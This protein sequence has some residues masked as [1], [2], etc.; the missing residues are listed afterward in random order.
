MKPNDENAKLLPAER[1]FRI[2]IISG[3]GRRQYNCPGVDSKSRTLMLKMAE[4]L[5]QDWEIDYE[6]LGNVY[7]RAR[8]QSCNA[9]VSTSMALCVYPCNCYEKGSSKE[10]DLMWDLDMYARF[11]MADAWAIIGPINWYSCS[12]NL[13]LMFD[14]MVCMNG[15]NPDEKTIDHKNPEKAMALEHTEEW[16]AMSINHLEGR[17]AGFFCYGDEGGDEMDENNVPKILEHKNYFD[18]AAEPFENERNAYA[19]LV[20]QCRYGGIEVP[21][22]LWAH[23]TSGKGK[24][25]SDNQAENLVKEKDFMQSFNKW[26][27]DFEEFVAKKGKVHHNKYRA[28]GYKAPGHRWANVKDG[29][30]YF[31]MMTGN[32]SEGSSPQIQEDLH[33]NKD[34]TWHTKKGE[35]EKLREDD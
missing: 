6:D 23:A 25:Y 22:N 31:K 3:S 20:W 32:A 1:P 12:S 28:F 24:K 33:L 7:A 16:K 30:R 13:K 11:D 34:A 5:P 4:M 18:G 21:D 14:R 35:G 26:V 15:G 27:K 29:I 8:I 9:C 17:T 2:L 10:P 19:P